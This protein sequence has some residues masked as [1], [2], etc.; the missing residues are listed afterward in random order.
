MSKYAAVLL[1]AVFATASAFAY[2]EEPIG[3]EKQSAVRAPVQ[4]SDAE[5]DEI[6]AGDVAVI[7]LTP[8]PNAHAAGGG[9]NTVL[10]FP[11]GGGKTSGSILTPNGV[12]YIPPVH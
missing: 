12:V 10:I 1:A 4:L 5:L 9:N 7:L 3:T 11:N 8:G 2:A 6:T